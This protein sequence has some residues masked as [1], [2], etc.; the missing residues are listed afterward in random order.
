MPPIGRRFIPPLYIEAGITTAVAWS[1]GNVARTR[2]AGLVSILRAAYGRT[3]YADSCSLSVREIPLFA[4]VLGSAC[5]V[6]L[7]F[8]AA[9]PDV[10]LYLKLF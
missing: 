6:S 1:L 3:M 7:D 10:L 8:V 2:V 9:G 5:T 4:A